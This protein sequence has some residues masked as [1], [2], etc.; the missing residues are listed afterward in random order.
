MQQKIVSRGE[1]GAGRGGSFS[2]TKLC[3]KKI[4]KNSIFLFKKKKRWA[5]V[6]SSQ[7]FPLSSPISSFSFLEPFS[8]LFHS[9]PPPPPSI[10][11]ITS[12]LGKPSLLLPS[13][14]LISYQ[15]TAADERAPPIPPPSNK[16]FA[17][18]STFLGREKGWERE[19]SALKRISRPNG[20][21]TSLMSFSSIRPPSISR[22]LDGCRS[23]EIGGNGDNR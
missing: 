3:H 22:L 19:G 13:P 9:H 1:S 5:L 2:H 14:P 17:E 4:F 15:G 11:Q 20:A 21:G 12:N 16:K 10:S 23:E 6:C 8:P 7:K 18:I